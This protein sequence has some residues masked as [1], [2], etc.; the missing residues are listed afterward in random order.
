MT[1]PLEPVVAQV[2]AWPDNPRTKAALAAYQ[3]AMRRCQ[4]WRHAVRAALAAADAVNGA[5]KE[6]KYSFDFI[7][8]EA[9]A[10]AERVNLNAMIDNALS[11]TRLRLDAPTVVRASFNKRMK[12]QVD[13]IARLAFAEGAIH[14]IEDFTPPTDA[15]KGPEKEDR[16]G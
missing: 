12:E 14:A 9:D 4:T 8:A 7:E 3:D 11:P 10:W 5:A 2:N 15:V 6:G 13:A 16:N 1:K